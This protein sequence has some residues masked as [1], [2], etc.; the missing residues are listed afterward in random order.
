M[1]GR[2]ISKDPNLIR[3]NIANGGGSVPVN[4]PLGGFHVPVSF[5]GVNFDE[6]NYDVPGDAA[7]VYNGLMRSNGAQSFDMNIFSVQ[8]MSSSEN[9]S[10]SGDNSYNATASY[11]WGVGLKS[12]TGINYTDIDFCFFVSTAGAITWFESGSNEGLVATLNVGEKWSWRLEYNGSTK[13]LELFIDDASVH[14]VNTG[15]LTVDLCI[16]ACGRNA[17]HRLVRHLALIK[18]TTPDKLLLL[19]GDSIS[20]GRSESTGFPGLHY[21]YRIIAYSGHTYYIPHVI[22][23]P[24]DETQDLIDDQLPLISK[25]YD[26]GKAANDFMFM[27]GVN[28][29]KSGVPEA[30]I[31][32][33]M[34]TINSFAQGIGYFTRQHT[35]LRNFTLTAPEEAIR[36]SIN[37]SIL[38]GTTGA[39]SSIDHTSSPMETDN[40]FLEG[41]GLH[42]NDRG[43]FQIAI[44]SY[45]EL[46]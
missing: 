43:Y 4:L 7:N 32:S 1:G 35:I 31:I 27:I 33:N 24:G 13:V 42:P 6:Y 16:K 8:T 40:R 44:E 3:Q 26:A 5:E 20:F 45:Q 10:L 36:Q 19:S 14:S 21:S 22:A 37:A 11:F 18:N 25:Y 9:W 17:N 41:D 2:V 15:Y 23:N 39:D 30:T 34:Q 46:L 12:D 28:D 38:D 29:I